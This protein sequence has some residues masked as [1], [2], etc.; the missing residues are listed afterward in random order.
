MVDGITPRGMSLHHLLPP[1]TV[2]KKVAEEMDLD[3]DHLYKI[4][5]QKLEP[6]WQLA[7][8]LVERF[9][10]IKRWMLKPS[11]WPPPKGKVAVQVP[12]DEDKATA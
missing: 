10:K 7:L 12:V 9:P 11:V 4:M 6:S 3:H 8:R 2:L 1:G 5:N